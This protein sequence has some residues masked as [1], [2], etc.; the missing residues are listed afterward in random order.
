MK[1]WEAMDILRSIDPNAEVTITLG[2]V[3]KVSSPTPVPAVGPGHYTPYVT[4]PTYEPWWKITCE[5]KQ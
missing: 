3:T 2:K 5:T 4:P 1:V